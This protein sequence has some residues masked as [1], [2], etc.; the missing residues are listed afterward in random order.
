MRRHRVGFTLV[1]LLVVIAIIGILIALLLPAVQAAREAARRSQ[2]SNNLRQLGLAMHEH[3]DTFNYL[4]SAGWSPVFVAGAN[5]HTLNG[6]PRAGNDFRVPVPV[7]AAPSI[8]PVSAAQPSGWGYQILP[9]L[10]LTNIHNPQQPLN[11]TDQQKYNLARGTPI[12][13]FACPTRRSG[14]SLVLVFQGQGVM[15]CDYATPSVTTN[16]AVVSTQGNANSQ[17]VN[18]VAFDLGI[19]IGAINDG[20]ANVFLVGEKRIPAQSYRALLQDYQDAG[21]IAGWN[22]STSV[23]ATTG[24]WTGN[25]ANA[26]ANTVRLVA[27]NVIKPQRNIQMTLA[28]FTQPRGPWSDN[29]QPGNGPT[30]LNAAAANDTTNPPTGDNRFGGPHPERMLMC[31]ADA[32]VHSIPF[33]IDLFT[34]CRLAHRNDGSPLEVP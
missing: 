34:F 22:G 2:C 6:V 16:G 3:H 9:Y 4:P 29:T 33:N 26:N 21:Y 27:S 13:T 14:G 7:A 32:S 12:P 30:G 19:Q 24:A 28:S 18:V 5:V 1:E 10:E 8:P 15:Q 17:D 20:T 11:L 31:Y 23:N 25:N